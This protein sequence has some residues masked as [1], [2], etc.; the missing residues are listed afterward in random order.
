MKHGC[1]GSY[2][3]V[4]RRSMGYNQEQ[5]MWRYF[6]RIYEGSYMH[7]MRDHA[8]S[9]YTSKLRGWVGQSRHSFN[10]ASFLPSYV[11]VVNCSTSQRNIET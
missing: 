10:S 3:H 8:M 1:R 11:Y 6:R 7:F 9:R 4:D 5:R 2:L